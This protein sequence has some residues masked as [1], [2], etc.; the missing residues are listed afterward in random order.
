MS[1]PPV[2]AGLLFGS[3]FDPE[4]GGC[5]VL[6]KARMYTNYKSLRTRKLTLLS[7]RRDN[8]KSNTDLY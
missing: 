8:V 7:Q 4:D 1:L 5:V 6:Q 3:L 2:F